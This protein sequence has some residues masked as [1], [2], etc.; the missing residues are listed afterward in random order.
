[1]RVNDLR[2]LAEESG[3]ELRRKKMTKSELVDLLIN[4]PVE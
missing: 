4:K 1:M 3:I 2:T